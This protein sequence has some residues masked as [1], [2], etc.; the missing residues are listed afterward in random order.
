MRLAKGMATCD[1]GDR[2]LVVHRHAEECFANVLGR[3][4]GIG[5]AVRTFG[6]DVDQPHLDGA[7][8]VL[9]LAFAAVALVAEPRPFRPPVELLR[10]PDVGAA[11]AEAEGLEAHRFQRDVAREDHEIRP[12]NFLAVLLLDRPKKPPRLVEVGVVRPTVEGGE[13]LLP[14]ARAAAPVGDAVRARAMPGHADEEPAV[15]A[16]IR[17][18]PVL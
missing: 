11:A 7:K 2:L 5:L 13:T 6:V 18:P 8:R 9:Q 1:Q 15:M 12:G 4:D 16:E 14:A 17:R 3:R 10:L